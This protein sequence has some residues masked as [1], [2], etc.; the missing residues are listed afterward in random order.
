MAY[1]P[2]HLI[3]GDGMKFAKNSVTVNLLRTISVAD[4]DE[5]SDEAE[6]GAFDYVRADI[7]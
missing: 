5:A 3:S 1:E 6:I 4:F 2:S 7:L